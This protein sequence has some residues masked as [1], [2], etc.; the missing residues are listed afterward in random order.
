MYKEKMATKELGEMNR[1]RKCK[2]EM[3]SMNIKH[4]N[5]K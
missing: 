2:G 1:R 3:T 5:V 4:L